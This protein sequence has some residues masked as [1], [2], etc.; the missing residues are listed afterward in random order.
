M[1]P[2]LSKLDMAEIWWLDTQK[3]FQRLKQ[4]EMLTNAGQIRMTHPS[5]L[6]W[7]ICVKGQNQGSSSWLA[8]SYGGNGSH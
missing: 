6:L 2:T 3:G 8:T 1:C 5:A 4:T 7:E